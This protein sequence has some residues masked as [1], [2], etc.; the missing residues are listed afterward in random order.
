[1]HHKGA[2]GGEGFAENH[3]EIGVLRK[4]LVDMVTGIDLGHCQVVCKYV[5]RWAKESGRIGVEKE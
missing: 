1:M 2:L 3:V 4:D 5:A